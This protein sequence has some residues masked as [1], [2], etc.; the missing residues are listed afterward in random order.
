MATTVKTA[1]LFRAEVDNTPGRLA[2]TLGPLAAAGTDL[3]V[4]MAYRIPGDR[5]RAAVEVY[6]VTGK[7]AVAAARGAGLSPMGAPMLVVEGDN[8]PGLGAGLASALASA[9]INMS[10]L[11]AQV[12]GRR[13]SAVFGFETESDAKKAAGIIRKAG[14]PART[15]ARRR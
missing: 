5:A 15:P 7:R 6:P 13:Y 14:A 3:Q 1:K 9:G 8:R 4:V 10:Y 11:V 12:T 2:D